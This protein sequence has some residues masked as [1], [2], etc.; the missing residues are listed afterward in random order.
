MLVEDEEVVRKVTVK[1]L[2]TFGYNVIES[3]NGNDAI[4]LYKNKKNQIDILLTDVIMPKMDGRELVKQLL[5]I[6]PK[7][8]FLYMSGYADDYIEKYKLLEEKAPFIKKPFAA[9]DLTFKIREVLD[10][11]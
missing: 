2:K 3:S 11:I 6:Q 5:Q 10:N 7:M 9:S 8:K 4:S 1:T